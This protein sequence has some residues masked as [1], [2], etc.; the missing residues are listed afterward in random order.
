MLATRPS[1]STSSKLGHVLR[2]PTAFEA[3]K[4]GRVAKNQRRRRTR[5]CRRVSRSRGHTHT[6]THTHTSEAWKHSLSPIT[7]T[8][9]IDFQPREW[10]R[11][12]RNAIPR[13]SAMIG[14]RETRGRLGVAKKLPSMVI[15]PG[16]VLTA[17]T[18]RTS[19]INRRGE[20]RRVE[21][22][23]RLFR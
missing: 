8:G 4:S 7:L 22:V 19:S 3:D 15:R 20:Y 1:N 14:S 17:D 10:P 9:M 21:R 11:I 6:H 16:G 18:V 13:V 23:I 12:A 5:S 2:A